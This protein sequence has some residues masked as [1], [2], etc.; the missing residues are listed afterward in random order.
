MIAAK[1]EHVS[2]NK[3]FVELIHEVPHKG[4][5][6][7]RDNKEYIVTKILWMWRVV[8]ARGTEKVFFVKIYIDNV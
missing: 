1:F 7:Y 3:D 6:I 4:D 2:E 8:L 5:F